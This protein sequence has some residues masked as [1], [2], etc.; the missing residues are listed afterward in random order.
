MST[1]NELY[2]KVSNRGRTFAKAQAGDEALGR[3]A[4]LP[5]TWRN[6]PNLPGRGWNMI[7][8]P[9]A[10]GPL[11]YRLLLNQYNET[12]TFT[13]VS[14]SVPNR[15]LIVKGCEYG[16]DAKVLPGNKGDQFIAALDYEQ[17]IVQIAADDFPHSG[18]AGKKCDP[19]HHEPGLW[20]HMINHETHCLDIARSASIPHG[21]SV[22]ALGRSDVI[23][24]GPQ[25]PKVSGLPEG[26]IA[27]LSNPYLAPYAH[28]NANLFEGV[29]NP[30][31][32]NDLL[33][34]ANQGV[35]IVKTTI[36]DVDTTR[37]T[38]GIHNIPFIVKQ[39]NATA[40][41]ST[42]WIQELA[43]KDVNGD[44][45]LRL[46]YSQ[47]IFLDFFPRKDGTPGL[48]RWPHVSINTLE[49]VPKGVDICQPDCKL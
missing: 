14:D 9:Y 31:S 41:K 11:H 24:S 43:D 20:L 47:V 29:F 39:A 19:I 40:M 36:L 3:L 7:A 13:D 25:I 44:P 30:V 27:D 6:V 18:L 33:I 35:K 28:F 37:E 32:P 10:D 49:K 38:G 16:N 4:Q 34:S 26:V 23:K 5:G 2:K 48:I 21:D 46:Q 8:L 1:I 42:F 17:N 45:V 15:G 22:L 12:L